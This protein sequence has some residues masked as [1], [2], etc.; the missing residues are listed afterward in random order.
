MS[1][2]N[3]DEVAKTAFINAGIPEVEKEELETGTYTN[4]EMIEKMRTNP[5]KLLH[6]IMRVSEMGDAASKRSI[7]SFAVDM[8]A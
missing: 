4:A 7:L 2:E 6:L 8:E 1:I 5:S 3:F